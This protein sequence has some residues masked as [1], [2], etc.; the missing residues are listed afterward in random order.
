MRSSSARL[1]CHIMLVSLSL[2]SFSVTAQQKRGP[3]TPKERERFVRY[4]EGIVANPL[5]DSLKDERSW[6]TV[7]L[8]EVPDISLKICRANAPWLADKS[9]K[10]S[11]ELTAV[12][13][14]A[15][16]AFIIQH[17]D[18][19]KNEA[20]INQAAIKNILLA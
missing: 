18:E 4:S 2:L 11:A 16:G 9:Y 17:P 20:A 13:M 19:A 14:A 3:S 8:I 6:A 12:S 10:Y 7:F 5:S 15:M 1:I